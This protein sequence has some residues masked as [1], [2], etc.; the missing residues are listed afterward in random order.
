MQVLIKGLSD[1][2]MDEGILK[3]ML[4]LYFDYTSAPNGAIKTESVDDSSIV[5]MQ[6]YQEEKKVII[7]I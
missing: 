2:I 6:K 4:A 7:S 1:K 5:V 3:S